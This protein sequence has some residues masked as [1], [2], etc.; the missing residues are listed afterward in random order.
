[1]V[2]FT[3]ERVIPG[4]VNDDLWNEHVARYAFARLYAKDKR[5]LDAGC[6]TGYGSAELALDAASVTALDIDAQ[7]VQYCSA[8]FPAFHLRA[9]TAS[10]AAMPFKANTFDLVVAF[11]VIEHL[12]EYRALLDECARVLTHQGLFVVSSPNKSYY[13]ESR[14]ATG[15]N[16]YHQHEFEPAEFVS[17]LERVFSNVR[18]MLQNRSEAFAFHSPK[19]MWPAQARIDGSAGNPEQA[20]FLIGLCSFGPLPEP[21]SFVYVPKATNLLREREQHIQ[22]LD[23]ELARAKQWLSETQAERDNLLALHRELKEELETRNRWAEKLD[24][25]LTAAGRRIVQLQEELPA[26]AAGYERKIAELEQE[27]RAKTQWALETEARLT[28]ELTAKCNEL[29]ECVRLLETAEATVVERTLWAQR[30]ESQREELAA[31]LEMVRSSRWVRL[32]RTVGIGPAL[33]K[34]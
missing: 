15:A 28:A 4:E 1:L 27:N 2:E 18:L 25:D 30:V 20:H 8:N 13:A 31:R 6:G 5:V 16:P 3:G 32:G 29:A 23:H 24:A 34:P 11:E 9:V 7:A 19:L 22:L 12:R 10:C 33:E 21:R 14:A 17:E 26:Q